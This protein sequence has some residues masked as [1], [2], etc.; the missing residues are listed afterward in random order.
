MH[1]K[2]YWYIYHVYSGNWQVSWIWEKVDLELWIVILHNCVRGK[3]PKNCFIC[4]NK[5]LRSQK[6]WLTY[7]TGD[8]PWC[9]QGVSQFSQDPP[10][11]LKTGRCC[12]DFRKRVACPPQRFLGWAY[13]QTRGL[14]P[15]CQWVTAAFLLSTSTTGD[16]WHPS[17]GDPKPHRKSTTLASR[18]RCR[19]LAQ[20]PTKPTSTSWL[21]NFYLSAAMSISPYFNEAI[22]IWLQSQIVSINEKWFIYPRDSPPSKLLYTS[23]GCL[24]HQCPHWWIKTE[25]TA[26][27]LLPLWSQRQCYD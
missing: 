3:G 27:K 8:H 16:W 17:R 26:I 24:S 13:H 1:C 21:P 15:W 22:L 19:P 18:F 9:S 14:P 10:W 5:I 20:K 11:I 2:K 23:A 12:V 4:I 25:S 6:S 7:M